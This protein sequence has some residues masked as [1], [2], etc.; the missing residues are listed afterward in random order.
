MS[1]FSEVIRGHRAGDSIFFELELETD[2][3]GEAVTSLAG[4]TFRFTLKNDPGD[5]DDDALAG[6]KTSELNGGID[7]VN[8][9]ARWELT[10]AQTAALPAERLIYFDVQATD[11]DDASKTLRAGTIYLDPQISITTP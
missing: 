9:L 10:P 4:Y 8:N 5:S 7:L 1:A 11:P 6:S 2:K 3:S